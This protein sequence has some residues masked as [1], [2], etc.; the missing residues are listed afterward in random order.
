MLVSINCGSVFLLHGK[1]TERPKPIGVFKYGWKK[2][3]E[4]ENDP[5]LSEEEQT[6]WWR[7]FKNFKH[8]VVTNDFSQSHA[9]WLDGDW[10]LHRIKDKLE[11]YN[12]KK[13][14]AESNNVIAKYPDRAKT[15]AKEL[16]AWLRSVELSM[17]GADY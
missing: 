3:N 16:E 11:L 4:R 5:W 14:P 9:A 15:M 6:G 13:D 1:M 7:T 17:S 8:P 12:L 10:K 2:T